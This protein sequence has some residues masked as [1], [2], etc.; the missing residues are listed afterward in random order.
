MKENREIISV[1]DELI[2]TLK[3]GQQGFKQ[4]T[5]AVSDRN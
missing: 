4:A 3:D 1:L 5:E 2:Q